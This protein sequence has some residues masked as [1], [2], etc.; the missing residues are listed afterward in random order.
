M[1]MIYCMTFNMVSEKNGHVKPSSPCWSRNLPGVQ[2]SVGKQTDLKLLDFSK[3]FDKVNHAKLLWTLHQYGIR[4]KA[5]G[6]IRAFLGSRSQSVVLD[7]E[8][9]DPVPVT[10]GVPHDSVLGPILFLIYINDLPDLI[11]S[12]VRLFADDTAV[13]LTVDSPS[14]GQVL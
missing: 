1:H 5:L 4:G 9:S 10:S 11:T 7:G 3:V 8:E 14:D 12:K 13:Y 6:R 2:A